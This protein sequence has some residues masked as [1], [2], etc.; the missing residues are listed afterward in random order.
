M[1]AD[2]SDWKDEQY[3][4]ASRALAR[5]KANKADAQSSQASA[6][7][8]RAALQ[9]GNRQTAAAIK[10]SLQEVANRREHLRVLE[11]SKKRSSYEEAVQSQYVNRAEAQR[12][13]EST[14]ELMA[15]AHRQELSSREGKPGRIIG[16]PNWRQ[17]LFSSGWFHSWFGGIPATAAQIEA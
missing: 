9:E 1:R 5:A 16:K 14:L 13:E 6:I 2:V 4:N 12:V 15:N 7:E 3:R 17:Y 10:A 8:G 11:E